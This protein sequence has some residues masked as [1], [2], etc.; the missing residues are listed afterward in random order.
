MRTRWGNCVVIMARA[1]VKSLRPLLPWMCDSV[2][3]MTR[4]AS[5]AKH[6]AQ[7]TMYSSDGTRITYVHAKPSSSAM[8]KPNPKMYALPH[9]THKSR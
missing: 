2:P 7:M 1:D 5:S 3:R 6:M 8:P 4:K 9:C